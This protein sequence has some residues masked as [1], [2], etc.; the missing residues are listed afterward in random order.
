MAGSMS[1]AD[2]VLTLKES[3]LDAADVFSLPGDADFERQLDVA[4]ADM[5]RV[6]PR[7]LIGRIEIEAGNDEYPAPADLVRYKSALWGAE[8]KR[9]P[10]W[11]KRWIGPL[12]SVRPAVDAGAKV[13]IF[14]PAPSAMQIAQLGSN[15]RFYYVA[16]D[17]IATAATATTICLEDRELLILRAQAEAMRELALRDSVRPV[18]LRDGYSA[19]AKTG[20]P[21]ALYERL[22]TDWLMHA[23]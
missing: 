7:T 15:F 13:L 1:R 23:L 10:P 12:P 22:M 21:A 2:L 9:I 18:Q 5:H 16:R 17:S 3:L 11:D 20:I 6:R 8:S 4:A 19:Q 14:S